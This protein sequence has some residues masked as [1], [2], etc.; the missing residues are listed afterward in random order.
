MQIPDDR[1]AV[2]ALPARLAALLAILERGLIE[3]GREV[4]LALLAALA[5]EHTLLI[6][7]PGTAKSE[8]ARRLHRAF[9]AA[10][11]FE[12][13]LTR[14]SVPEELFGPLSISAL[15]QDR[16]ERHTAGFLPEASIAFIDEVFKANS[17][18]LNALLTLLNEREF[19][20][21]AGRQ[22]CPL[23]SVIGAT[24]EV[25]ADE[26]A[27]AFFDRF[28]LRLPVS[29]V[30]EAGFGGLLELEP[31]VG[32]DVPQ[33][34]DEADRAV[35]TARAV[36]VRL[37]AAVAGLLAELRGRLAQGG[38]YVS[39]RRWV[40]IAALLRVAAASEG[41]PGVAVWDLWLL[42]WCVAPDAAGQ[43]EIADWLVTRLGVREVLSPPRLTRVVEAFEAQLQGE[44]EANDLDYD[45]AGRLRFSAAEVAGELAGEVGEVGD[46]KGGARALRMTYARKR[47]YGAR[48]IGARTAQIDELLACIDGYAAELAAQ[49]AELGAYVAQSLWLD[50][51]FAV[52]SE[53]S[54]AATAAA[55]ESL[56]MRTLAAREGFEALPRLPEDAGAV[57]APVGHEPLD[58]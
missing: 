45:E 51:D 47:C 5:G 57:P 32:G 9:S 42:P 19:D 36:R 58:A 22:R 56:R 48:H 16:Y 25:P 14:F 46:A 28:L 11:Y 33:A 34:L 55:L 31:A 49:R 8:L 26:V 24:N 43:R 27:E 35:L 2:S 54:L 38:H 4:R 21:G 6:G 37:P 3:R 30:S 39:D 40:K 41:R 12:R 20:N 18:I 23:V 13:L 10:A 7:P 17:A 44:R 1:G 52:R 53:A 29:P 15:E 50:P